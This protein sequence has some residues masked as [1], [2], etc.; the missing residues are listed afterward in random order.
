MSQAVVR[1]D[2]QFGEGAIVA[3]LAGF[4]YVMRGKDYHLLDREAVQARLLAP[5]DV[6]TTH[7]ET[8]TQRALFD[9]PRL[10]VTPASQPCRVIVATHPA[11]SQAARI[12]TT[13][14]D[15][16]SE[17]FFTALP[18]GAFSAADVVELYLHR[19]ASAP[20]LSD[21]DQEQAPD[22]WCSHTACGQGFWQILCPW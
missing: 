19:G 10:Q 4:A 22:R 12:G 9:F 1:L 3:D 13:R 16:V 11:S 2:G 15:V 14:D 21:E 6:Q 5:P 18:G 8:G 17:L 20:V 7:P